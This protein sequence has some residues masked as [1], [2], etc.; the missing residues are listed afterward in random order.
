MNE[1][2]ILNV[3]YGLICQSQ[4]YDTKAEAPELLYHLAFNDGVLSLANVLIKNIE[5]GKNNAE[6][7]EMPSDSDN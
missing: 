6:K 2:E 7:I 1:Q 4:R 5:G 3:A